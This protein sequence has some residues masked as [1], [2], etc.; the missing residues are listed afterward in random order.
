[1]LVDHR[2]ANN[3]RQHMMNELGRGVG[4]GIAND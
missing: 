1:M 4:R 3:E 2:D